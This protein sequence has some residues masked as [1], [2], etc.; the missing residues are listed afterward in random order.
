MA[1][2]VTLSCTQT[3]WHEKVDADWSIARGARSSDSVYTF[4]SSR[5]GII[6][7]GYNF[8]RTYLS[9]DLSSLSIP[10][11]SIIDEIRLSL[12]RT[13]LLGG[14]YSPIIAYAGKSS[15]TLSNNEYPLYID[16]IIGGSPLSNITIR[17]AGG[18]HDSSPFDLNTYPIG[19]ND[20]LT[21][22]IIDALDFDNTIDGFDN[23]Y[24]IDTD[25]RSPNLPF[26]TITYTEGGGGYPNIVMGVPSANISTVMGVPTANISK[27]MGV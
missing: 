12:K 7:A 2:T 25:T 6:K 18:I 19:I 13:D 10:G 21:V 17:G 16:N 15:M 5:V 22:G 8:Y 14:N 3:Q 26:L 23:I 9:F 27:V 4:S 11:G 24:E 1:T 20:I